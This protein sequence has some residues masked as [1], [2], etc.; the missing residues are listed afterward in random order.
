V[1]STRPR[2]AVFRTRS[3][4]SVSHAAY[5]RGTA[6]FTSRKRWFTPRISTVTRAPGASAAPAPYPVMLCTSAPPDVVC[7]LFGGD[8]RGADLSDDDTRRVVGEQRGLLERAA[9]AE[10]QGAGREHRVARAGHVE[11]LTRHGRELL[12]DHAARPPLEERHPLLAA[13]DEHGARLPSLQQ[14]R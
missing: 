1:T 14:P 13:R 6:T 7:E 10:C 12:D 9:R 3:R 8:R 11:D 5:S 4:I 2:W